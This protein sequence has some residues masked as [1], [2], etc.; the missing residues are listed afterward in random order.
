[1]ATKPKM[2]RARVFV[3]GQN[4][5]YAL[6]E[7][8]GYSYPNYD[9][10]KLARML[11]ERQGWQFAGAHFYTGIPAYIDDP[12]WN[13]F[14]QNKLATMG[15]QG[16]RVFSRRLHY[17]NQ[18]VTLPDGTKQV[19]PVGQEKGI[20]VRLALD[21][22]RAV[23]RRQCDVVLIFSQ[24]QDLSEVA[25]E[26]RL[27]AREEKRWVKMASAFPISPTV[28]NHYGINKTDWITVDRATYDTCLDPHDYRPKKT[29]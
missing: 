6:K 23:Y 15:R 20:D 19:F 17:R 25:E 14:W 24:D 7:A 3:D 10:D 2:P 12:F 1:M 27:I 13:Q 28:R 22:V 21:V 26:V 16:V 11:C 9:I 8:F 5:F 29:P 18:T 4:L